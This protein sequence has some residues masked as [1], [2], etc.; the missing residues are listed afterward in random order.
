[1]KIT[2]YFPPKSSFL[3]I[4]KDMGII[5]E[6]IIQNPR[7]KKLLYYTSRD[8][9]EKPDLTMDQ[10]LEVFRNNI[11]VVPKLYVDGKVLNYLLIRFKN[12]LPTSNPEYRANIIEFDCVCH[13]D[14]WQMDDFKLRPY[15]MAAEIDEMFSDKHLT[16]IGKLEFG[17]AGEVVV[18]DEFSGCCL[19]FRAVHGEEDKAPMPGAEE[20]W[21]RF[22]EEYKGQYH[23][24]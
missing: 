24:F 11:K 10:S 9:L 15:R 8:A 18:N 14:Q 4:E 23:L 12:F 22:K 5:S 7:L 1:M 20:Q 21:E 17:A 3:S 2:R 13:F 16:G 19:I 6:Q